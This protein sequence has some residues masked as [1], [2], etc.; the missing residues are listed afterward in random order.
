[1]SGTRN[2]AGIGGVEALVGGHSSTIHCLDLSQEPGIPAVSKSFKCLSS[3][4]CSVFTRFPSPGSRNVKQDAL[5]RQFAVT[6]GNT[7][8]APV[9]PASFAIGSLGRLSPPSP[10]DRPRSWEWTP[11]SALCACFHLRSRTAL[12]THG[13]I[14]LSSWVHCTIAFLQQY[15]WWPTLSRN[16]REY[17]LACSVCVQNKSSS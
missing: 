4:V 14:Y 11:R 3:Q 2:Q 9:L 13:L 17:V 10:A 6:E 12:G 15:F 8:S 5:S 7:D 16:V 1:M